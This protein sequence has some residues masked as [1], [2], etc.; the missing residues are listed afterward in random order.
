M[1]AAKLITEREFK[2]A[3]AYCGT[4]RHS[5]RDQTILHLSYHAGLRACELAALTMGN[6][7]NTD[8]SV[9]S[10]VT[11]LSSQTKGSR[12]RTFYV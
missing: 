2:R 6:V 12:S 10:T 5:V 3:L 9:K 1:P 11:L 7:Y 8:G 4:R